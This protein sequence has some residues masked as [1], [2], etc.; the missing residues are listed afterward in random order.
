MIKRK[1][2]KGN[3]MIIILFAIGVFII[4]FLGV[5]LAIGGSILNYTFD[6]VVPELTTIGVVGDTNVTE[7]AEMTITPLNSVV[8]ATTW[9][10]GL[11]FVLMLVASIGIVFV[12]RISANKW[13]IGFYFMIAILMVIGAM[14]IANIYEDF[15]NDSSE[16]GTRL[17]EQTLLSYMILYSPAIFSVIIFLTGI[18]LFSGFQEDEYSV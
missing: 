8:Q 16:L 11:L 15:Y 5:L 7:V 1:N 3:V 14:F 6:E 18:I 13:L 9:V 17:Q 2:K 10:G 4:L 12:A